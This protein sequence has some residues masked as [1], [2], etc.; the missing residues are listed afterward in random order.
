MC[1]CEDGTYVLFVCSDYVF[2]GV[3]VCSVC[4]C[5]DDI[6]PGFGF[7]VNVLCVLFECHPSV[8]CHSKD[9]GS[10]VDRD[11]GVEEGYMWLSVIFSIVRCYERKG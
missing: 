3:T 5:S 4:E 9:C 1:V 8:Q 2:L 6:Q 7:S 10:V 11:G